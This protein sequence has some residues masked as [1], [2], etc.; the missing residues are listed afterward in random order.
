MAVA[1][2]WPANSMEGGPGQNP[3]PQGVAESGGSALGVNNAGLGSYLSLQT[4][5]LPLT[6]RGPFANHPTQLPPSKSPELLHAL[7]THHRARL[8]SR[9]PPVQTQAQKP[10]L[11][12]FPCAFACGQ[13]S[14]EESLLNFSIFIFPTSTPQTRNDTRKQT[15]GASFQGH[16]ES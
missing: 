16:C 14:T 6:G 2:E 4:L 7:Q 3:Q 12:H 15:I 11:S 8:D 9:N 5:P 1:V 13:A 10:G